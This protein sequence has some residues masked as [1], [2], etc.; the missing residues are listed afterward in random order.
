MTCRC[1]SARAAQGGKDISMRPPWRQPCK[2]APH[3]WRP[4]QWDHVSQNQLK[5]FET[6]LRGSDDCIQASGR[7][8]THQSCRDACQSQQPSAAQA[9][10][11]AYR[12][13]QCQP[14]G[15]GQPAPGMPHAIAAVKNHTSRQVQMQQL[16]QQMSVR[17]DRH[18]SHGKS[19]SWLGQAAGYLKRPYASQAGVR[20]PDCPPTGS[21]QHTSAVNAP[22]RP[23]SAVHMAGRSSVRQH[24]AGAAS[25]CRAGAGFDSRSHCKGSQGLSTAGAVKPS[26]AVSSAKSMNV[27]AAQHSGGQ[28]R[29][30]P[31]S[32]GQ[33]C[34]Q[35][36]VP[37]RS[38]SA[39][40]T[41][42]GNWIRWEAPE[43]TDEVSCS[44]ACPPARLYA[45]YSACIVQQLF[46]SHSVLC[47]SSP[48]H[49]LTRLLPAQVV[50]CNL[51]SS[52]GVC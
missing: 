6:G 4:L 23:A 19:V 2:C 25:S 42:M 51:S 14:V 52:N 18:V 10:L 21:C 17:P 36:V 15:Q 34:G 30:Q 48:E 12:Q 37:A 40:P 29:G 8:Q 35:G 26:K 3:P 32:R 5:A 9:K 31:A 7:Q 44:Q 16:Q 43:N 39:S 24:R 28:S 47:L 46:H 49:P 33:E 13:S 20:Q 38:A 41:V 11:H 1:V 27:S 45:S 50:R 22:D